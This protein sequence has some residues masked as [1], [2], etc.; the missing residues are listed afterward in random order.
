[1]NEL[2]QKYEEFLKL[3]VEASS[4]PPGE[5]RDALF[6]RRALLFED[7]KALH[8]ESSSIT[9]EIRALIIE[10]LEKDLELTSLLIQ[11]KEDIRMALERS[12]CLRKA[13]K[14]YQALSHPQKST[15]RISA[16][17]KKSF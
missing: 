6:A 16:S 5:E 9:D 14:S 1:M 7:I 2:K 11:E 10:V 3:V 8:Q 17:N 4:V 15:Q 12:S 13:Q